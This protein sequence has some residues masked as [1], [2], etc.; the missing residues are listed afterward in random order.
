MSL[1]FHG[2][3]AMR[4]I[5]KAFTVALLTVSFCCHDALAVGYEEKASSTTQSRETRKNEGSSGDLLTAI[6]KATFVEHYPGY[7]DK[8]AFF[9]KDLMGQLGLGEE[10]GR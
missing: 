6:K 2:G 8:A 7:L 4:L 5:A 1:F 10:K 9:I 3:M